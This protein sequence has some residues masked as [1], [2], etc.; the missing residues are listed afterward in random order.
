MNTLKRNKG[1]VYIDFGDILFGLVAL[2]CIV[3]FLGLLAIIVIEESK[4]LKANTVAVQ[5]VECDPVTVDSV[6]PYNCTLTISAEDQ[7]MRDT[8]EAN[9]YLMSL[10]YGQHRVGQPFPTH[11][12]E[13]VAEGEAA[14][15]EGGSLTIT[16]STEGNSE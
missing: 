4:P 16:V 14:E 12:E 3:G 9:G 10:E 11:P 5:T 15:S 2:C 6:P 7:F 1:Y 13:E 8:F